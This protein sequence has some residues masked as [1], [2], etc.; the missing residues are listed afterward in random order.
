MSSLADIIKKLNDTDPSL[1]S[2]FFRLVNKVF[3][4]DQPFISFI[5]TFNNCVNDSDN[6]YMSSQGYPGSWHSVSAFTGCFNALSKISEISFIRDEIGLDKCKALKNTA[7]HMQKFVANNPLQFNIDP[8]KAKKSKKNNKTPN[9][10][11]NEAK[12]NIVVIPDKAEQA[13]SDTASDSDESIPEMD[14]ITALNELRLANQELSQQVDKL[15]KT[16]DVYKAYFTRIATP[17]VATCMD[18]MQIWGI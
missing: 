1:A 9:I 11:N 14:V 10:A 18:I 5:D 13:P 15:K 2:A 6:V 17:E 8:D 3:K 7:L 16:I 12:D 4:N